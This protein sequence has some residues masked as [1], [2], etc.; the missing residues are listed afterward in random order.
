MPTAWLAGRGRKVGVQVRGAKYNLIADPTQT[1]AMRKDCAPE[2]TSEGSGKNPK[3]MMFPAEVSDGRLI[4]CIHK[5]LISQI[6]ICMT[7]E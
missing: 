1:A 2:E 4:L 3:R 6:L 5:L 7:K